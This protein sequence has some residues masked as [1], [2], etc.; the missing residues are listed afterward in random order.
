MPRVVFGNLYLRAL[1]ELVPQVAPQRGG[2]PKSRAEYL[3]IYRAIEKRLHIQPN[4]NRDEEPPFE[5]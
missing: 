1:I 2:R 5:I 3:E 4:D